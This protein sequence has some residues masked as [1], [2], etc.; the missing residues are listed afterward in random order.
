[1]YHLTCTV[2]YTKPS[3]SPDM[4]NESSM[5]PQGQVPEPSPARPANSSAA[6]C[7]RG[8]SETLKRRPVLDA[9][10]RFSWC[11]RGILRGIIKGNIY[12]DIWGIMLIYCGGSSI[13]MIFNGYQGG[14]LLGCIINNVM[15]LTI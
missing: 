4:V 9:D 10:L 11:L 6:E 1:M 15:E 8:G 5:S 13:V 3:W 7:Q 2:S 12:W 14:Y